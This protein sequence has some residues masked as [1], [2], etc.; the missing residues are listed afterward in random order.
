MR[1]I[2]KW[3]MIL[4]VAGGTLMG[5]SCATDMRDAV[6]SGAYDFLSGTTTDFLNSIVDTLF[7][8]GQQ[9]GEA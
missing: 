2:T 9:A 5:T 7:N 6:V 4:G 8:G 3:L 1:T